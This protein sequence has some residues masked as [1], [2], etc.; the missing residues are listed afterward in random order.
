MA[1]SILANMLPLN[2]MYGRDRT[3]V[4]RCETKKDV[5]GDWPQPVSCFS[6]IYI[7]NVTILG[8]GEGLG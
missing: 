3:G 6:S 7:D 1:I 4:M 2:R 8:Q 5:S